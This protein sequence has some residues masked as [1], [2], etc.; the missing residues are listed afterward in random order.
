MSVRL[1]L[2]DIKKTYRAVTALNSV[3][4]DMMGGK[5]IVLL[6]ANGAGK[7]TLMRILAGLEDPDSGTIQ[8][9]NQTTDA[10][11]IRRVST[12]VFQKSVMF[13]LSVYGNL[14]Y[15][16]K[17]RGVPEG[18]ISKRIAEALEAVR[19]SGF[20]KRRAKKA[21]GRRAAEGRVGTGVSA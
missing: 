13:S 14:A 16:L 10:K 20:E 6:G 9:N 15:G 1:Q 3:S 5:I 8:F 18:E 12:L 4:L 17:I 19:L 2:T 7:S 11:S 21:V